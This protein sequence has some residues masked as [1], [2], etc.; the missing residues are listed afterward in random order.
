MLGRD[1]GRA[2]RARACTTR[3]TDIGTL[4]AIAAVGQP[5]LIERIG[6]ILGR[7]GAARGPGAAHAPRLRH[8]HRSTCT[9]ARRCGASSTSASCP[10]STRTTPSPT[11][12]SA[13]ATTTG[14]PRWS[15]HLVGAD[16]LVLLTDTAGLFTADPRLDADA[17]LIE[18]IVEVDAALEAVAGGTGHRAG[19]RRHGDQARGGQDR[20]VVGRAGGD[21]GRRRARRR[22]RRD[23]RAAGRHRRPRPG[24]AA[25]EPQAL[26]RVRPCRGR[27]GRRRRRR[28]PALC[29]TRP[30]LAAAGR[31]PRRRGRRS[32][33]TTR[34]RSSTT[35]GAPFAKGLVRY[36]PRR[37]C[38]RVAGRQTVRARR[39]AAPRG[40]PPRRPRRPPLTG[41]RPDHPP[42]GQF[43]APAL[44]H[45]PRVPSHS[46]LTSSSS[47]GGGRVLV[48][49]L[50]RSARSGRKVRPGR[51]GRSTP[52][53]PAGCAAGERH[54]LTPPER[55]GRSGAELRPVVHR[56]RVHSPP[57][58]RPWPC[59]SSGGGPRPP[60]RA[61]ASAST[62]DKNAALLAAA[63]LLDAARRRAPG[64]QRPTSRPPTRPGWT[65]GRSTACASPTPG[66]RAWP[67]GCARSPALPDPVGEVLDGWRRPNGLRIERVPGAARRGRDHLREPAQRHQRRRRPLPEVGQRRA[68]AGLGRPRCART[69]PSPRCCAT[70]LAKAGLPA[71]AVLLV[72]DIRHEAAVEFMQLTDVRRLPHPARRPVAHPEHPRQRH[73]ARHHRRRRQLP[74]LRRR[75]RRPRRWRST[76]WST[77]R[78]SARAC[79]TRPSRWSCTR[80]S[81][82]RSCPASPTALH[83]ARRRAGRRRRRPRA[84]RRHMG[85]ATDDDFGREFLDL[86][87]SVAVVAVARRRH[88]R[89]STATAPGTP[90]RSSPATSTPPGASPTRSTP[91]PCVVNA[92]TRFTDG[93]EFGFGA[94]IGISHPEAARPR[95]DGPA[96]AHHLQVRRLG[97]R[98]DPRLT[99][100]GV[101]LMAE[102]FESVD[103]V[104]D[105]PPR[106]STTSPTPA[107]PAS[108]SSPTGSRSR[109]SSRAR[110][111]SAR[112]S[113]PRRSPRSPA[114]G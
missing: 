65:P 110:P 5:R 68:P 59:P 83:R 39:R 102:R 10:S 36:S 84:R 29:A 34:S 47:T 63:D 67:T 3:P 100:P 64:R 15:S 43:C 85:A 72:D 1:R 56:P 27:P 74:R 94:E 23:R 101:A 90:R 17:S 33:P 21:R 35:T 71:D 49:G 14:S 87:M 24:R 82:T 107:S 61:L 51:L 4:Q 11:T 108:C 75:R 19:E 106:A 32:R 12:R 99:Q 88:R 77:P 112:P 16:V 45:R 109:S 111:A 70:A 31:R 26:D 95:P 8:A 80:R 42:Q 44:A 7:H 66:S 6:A 81:P 30:P 91:P 37:C 76:S 46:C 97:R 96:R 28:P 62:A 86:K 25:P 9:R 103:D 41:S 18:E 13:T 20:G 79:A 104:T 73:R 48:R 113:W 105:A 2:A 38:E 78:R 53:R 54:G 57:C 50:R 40:R 114:P 69:S 60:P 89:T 22:R 52:G 58:P 93:E 92:S 98:P 55:P